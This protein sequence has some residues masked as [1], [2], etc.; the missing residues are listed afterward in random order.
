[1]FK[2]FTFFPFRDL[3]ALVPEFM[4]YYLFEGLSLK[5]I[6]EKYYNSQEY[7]GWFCKSLLNY[8]GIDTDGDNRGVYAGRSIKDVVDELYTS[9]NL[10]HLMVAKILKDKYL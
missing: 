2:T 10:Q 3:E 1:M 9:T 7:K 6:E 5:T 4:Y 8:Y